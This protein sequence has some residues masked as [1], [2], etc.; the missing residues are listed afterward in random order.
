MDRSVASRM[1]GNAVLE[2]RLN[3]MAQPE[4]AP[5]AARSLALPKTVT[6]ATFAT[7]ATRT[8]DAL[9]APLPP[10]DIPSPHWAGLQAVWTARQ[11]APGVWTASGHVVPE[12]AVP[13]PGPGPAG[14]VLTLRTF[15]TTLGLE[16]AVGRTLVKAANLVSLLDPTVADVRWRLYHLECMSRSSKVHRSGLSPPFEPSD[17]YNH[18]TVPVVDERAI[19]EESRV[20]DEM[21]A[22]QVFDFI[23]A[24]E[25]RTLDLGDPTM[26]HRI[27]SAVA[28]DHTLA[29]AVGHPLAQA[30]RER[31]G[32]PEPTPWAAVDDDVRMVFQG[33]MG[34]WPYGETQLLALLETWAPWFGHATRSTSHWGRLLAALAWLGST[35]T[36]PHRQPI[37]RVSVASIVEQSLRGLRV[38]LECYMWILMCV[39]L[40]VWSALGLAAWSWSDDDNTFTEEDL[41]DLFHQ[42]RHKDDLVAQMQYADHVTYRI[43]VTN[44]RPAYRQY[45]DT[46]RREIA[47]LRLAYLQAMDDH[48]GPA[49]EYDPT[50]YETYMSDRPFQPLDHEWHTTMADRLRED[51]IVPFLRRGQ[52]DVGTHNVRSFLA[53]ARDMLRRMALGVGGKPMP[54]LYHLSGAYT[55]LLN[56]PMD[57]GVL[58][59]SHIAESA[60]VVMSLCT[61]D[62]ARFTPKP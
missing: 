8:L 25:A 60:R 15:T 41:R 16:Y 42:L 55:D 49:K 17:L 57:D 10:V 13:D 26:K 46:L 9:H 34:Q 47:S 39:G 54:I 3:K 40:I 1:P 52:Y 5:R 4:D 30:I 58:F 6:D 37:V 62:I 45:L 56:A 2:D 48:G 33:L 44:T 27:F 12:E 19:E 24:V 14:P 23:T 11:A 36:P 53:R 61:P 31:Y 28:D 51:L 20:L 43:G 29:S 35:H 18:D 50:A 38:S 21:V 59:R 7:K 22:I 32:M